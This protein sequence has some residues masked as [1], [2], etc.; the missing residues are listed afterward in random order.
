MV[1]G[2][3]WKYQKFYLVRPETLL[4]TDLVIDFKNRLQV[5]YK[6]TPITLAE[7]ILLSYFWRHS[8]TQRN[9]VKKS[10]KASRN[11]QRNKWSSSLSFVMTKYPPR[12]QSNFLNIAFS[13][14]FYSDKMPCRRSWPKQLY[15]LFKVKIWYFTERDFTKDLTCFSKVKYMK[16]YPDIVIKTLTLHHWFCFLRLILE[17]TSQTISQNFESFQEKYLRWSSVIVKPLPLRFTVILF[18][19]L[20]LL[21]LWNVIMIYEA[22]FLILVCSQPYL[23]LKDT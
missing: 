15:V 16:I 8:T 12:P 20:K 10:T 22:L 11:L 18:M 14:S 6:V 1:L 19:F 7:E 2:F 13:P 17:N 21:I 23:N 9:F 3:L 5:N 4:K